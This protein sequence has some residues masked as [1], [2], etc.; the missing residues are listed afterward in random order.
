[1]CP[2]FQKC[3]KKLSQTFGV[4][5]PLASF[6]SGSTTGRLAG[7][8]ARQP[9]GQPAGWPAGLPEVHNIT[10]PKQHHFKNYPSA[11]PIGRKGELG[12]TFLRN[13]S[14]ELFWENKNK[15]KQKQAKTKTSKAKNKQQN[16]SK[17]KNKKKTKQ[18]K[19]SPQF[20]PSF[21]LRPEATNI[22]HKTWQYEA[23][24]KI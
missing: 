14:V 13:L 7:Q 23:N 19:P 18:K 6:S 11:T 12:G 2:P 16:K 8:P 3:P 24:Q 9:A 22:Q 20:L 10:T 17:K 1:M 5:D 21:F 4:V 15:N